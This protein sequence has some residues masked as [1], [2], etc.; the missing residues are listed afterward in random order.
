M[1]IHHHRLLTYRHFLYSRGADR[2]RPMRR[3]YASSFL[4]DFG[5]SMMSLFVLFYLYQLGWSL[6]VIV[7]YVLVGEILKAPL[8][9]L[10]NRLLIGWGAQKLALIGNIAWILFTVSLLLVGQ[11]DALGWGL[12]AGAVIL[13][14]ASHSAYWTAWDFNLISFEKPEKEG[15]Q[16]SLIWIFG[17]LSRILAPVAGGVIAQIWG[18]QASLVVA[19][20]LLLLS[21][22]PLVGLKSTADLG[23]VEKIK[24]SLR[25]RPLWEA[26]KRLPKRKLWSFYLSHMAWLIGS[27]WALWLAIAIFTTQTYSGLGILFAASSVVS[28]AISWLVGRLID[29]GFNRPVLLTSSLLESLLSGLKLAVTGVPLAVAHN[30]LQQQSAGYTLT[31]FQWYFDKKRPREEQLAFFQVYSYFFYFFNSLILIGLIVCLVVFSDSQLEVLRLSSVFLGI[32]VG[33]LVAGLSVKK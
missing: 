8:R 24:E 18:F 20:L 27:L 13:D 14:A 16:L 3:F 22:G 29:K 32:A 6:P 10:G 21:V 25:L 33:L 26:Y 9:H 19:G 5:S 2:S 11:P 7:G 28:M 12:L 1:L 23:N 15:K 17:D 31:T 4:H 30:F